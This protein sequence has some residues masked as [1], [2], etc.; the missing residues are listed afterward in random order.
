MVGKVILFCYLPGNFL[1]RV[2]VGTCGHNEPVNSKGPDKV[3][4][5][6]CLFSEELVSYTEYS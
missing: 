3:V 4:L 2:Q 1:A 5:F 6:V